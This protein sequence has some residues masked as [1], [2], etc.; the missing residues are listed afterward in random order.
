MF[1]TKT[2]KNCIKLISKCISRIIVISEKLE[3]DSSSEFGNNNSHFT[4]ISN[5]TRLYFPFYSMNPSSV[6]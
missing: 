2:K 6:R 5:Y 4:C 1:N 3:G